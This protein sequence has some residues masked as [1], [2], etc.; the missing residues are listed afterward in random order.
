MGS[1]VHEGM[2]YQA[3]VMSLR[4][5]SPPARDGIFARL[6]GNK[7]SGRSL[8]WV[9]WAGILWLYLPKWPWR[10]RCGPDSERTRCFR[11]SWPTWEGINSLLAQ[12][13]NLR[14]GVAS[15]R[16]C[17]QISTARYPRRHS[18]PNTWRD[19]F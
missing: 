10:I 8:Q 16:F 9:D 19:M 12:Y 2:R 15:P 14:I 13:G 17:T 6:Y 4:R 5:A 18:V 7:E 1:T 11:Q 3:A